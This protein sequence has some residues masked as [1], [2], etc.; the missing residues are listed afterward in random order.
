VLVCREVLCE[1]GDQY[2][3]VVREA[4]EPETDRRYR[5]KPFF[6][7]HY[8]VIHRLEMK[9]LVHYLGSN[10]RHLT[11]RVPVDS[12]MD[13]GWGSP[14]VLEILPSTQEVVVKV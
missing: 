7:C 11:H 6:V 9:N 8:E 1:L 4:L 14:H 13:E 2:F 10:A 12:Q 5:L 3:H